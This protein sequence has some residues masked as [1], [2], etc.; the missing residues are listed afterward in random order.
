MTWVAPPRVYSAERRSQLTIRSSTSPSVLS[1]RVVSRLAWNFTWAGM[2][3]GAALRGA[4]VHVIAPALRNAPSASGP[5]MAGA[6]AVLWRLLT[7]GELYDAEI[8][9]AGGALRVGLYADTSDVDDI[10]EQAA[11]AREGIQRTPWLR[12]LFPFDS[13]TVH[14]LDTVPRILRSAG[15]AA[16]SPG[17]DLVHRLPQLH[18]KVVFVADSVALASLLA[19]PQW[20]RVLERGLLAR[21]RQTS[22]E[23][24]PRGVAAIRAMI[25]QPGAAL[26]RGYERAFARVANGRRTSFH[27]TVGTQNHDPRGMLLDGEATVVV[28]GAGATLAVIDLWF[29][30]GRTTW[31][32]RAAE[33]DALLPP[34]SALIQRAANFLR[35]IL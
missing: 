21:A 5:V 19:Q 13:A 12:A 7:T 11:R 15:Y 29:L 22:A 31:I 27:L 9:R 14:V 30:M 1:P 3:A 18:A 24:D 35:L 10:A 32:T 4:K 20:P 28:S 2:L 26:L 33:L 23:A 6:H 8:A 25:A 34:P 17:R 16:E